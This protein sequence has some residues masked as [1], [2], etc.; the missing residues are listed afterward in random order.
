MRSTSGGR[1]PLPAEGAGAVSRRA[2]LDGLRGFA[3]LLGVVLHATL[4]F[5]ALFG[6]SADV[7]VSDA[8]VYDALFSAIHGF[9]MPLFFLLSGF[10]TTLVWRRQGAAVLVR[11]RAQR[12]ALPLLIGTVTI[13]PVTEAAVGLRFVQPPGQPFS[14]QHLW[15]LWYLVLFI[16]AFV[17]VAG[18]VGRAR[19]AE[20]SVAVLRWSLV[21]LTLVPQLLMGDGGMARTFGPDAS[22]FLVPEAHE[23]GYFALFFAFGALTQGRTT[24]RGRPVIDAVGTGWP[25]SGVLALVLLPVGLELTFSGGDWVVASVVQVAYAWL[26]T[27]ALIGLFRRLI[28]G[29]RRG[30]R[31]LADASY[32][33][34]L[35]HLPLVLWL[36][37]VVASWDVAAPLKFVG[38][39]VI[40]TAV[41]LA[42]Y[43]LLVRHTAI[44]TI[45]NGRRARRVAAA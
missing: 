38:I 32:W 28:R 21:P 26:T 13:V 15:F 41:G 8:S 25:V 6:G 24:A 34:Y 1:M 10:F 45:L 17:L 44:G 19:P 42:S 22:P 36:Q 31:Y 35:S 3:M 18:S 37:S 43:Q 14:F 39:I 11:Q 16:A 20:R 9:R 27:F 23:L 7:M 33:I 29:E 2:D 40:A 4:S 5:T 12:V 30:V